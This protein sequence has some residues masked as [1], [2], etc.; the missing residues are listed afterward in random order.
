MVLLHNCLI[1]VFN[2]FF[3]S[4]ILKLLDDERGLRDKK[5][6]GNIERKHWCAGEGR[7]T[8]HDSWASLAWT[9]PELL[10]SLHILC[11]SLI[12]QSLLICQYN[13]LN[14]SFFFLILSFFST[15][16]F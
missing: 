13:F 12:C 11:L 16:I 14:F 7:K 5:T 8:C 2:L 1:F 6:G 10:I 3:P 15:F 9:G 4:S